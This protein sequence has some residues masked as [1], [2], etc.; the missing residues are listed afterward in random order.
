M[1]LET[2]GVNAG[3]PSATPVEQGVNSTAPST[4]VIDQQFTATSPDTSVV[5]TD[6]GVPQGA[7]QQ[8]SDNEKYRAI[9]AERDRVQFEK[10]QLQEQLNQTQRQTTELMQRF[11]PQQQQTNPYDPQ[12][13]NEQYWDWKL[14]QKNKQLLVES[15]R[16]YESKLMGLLQ[17]A[18]EQS[19]VQQHPDV[20]VSQIK[21]QIKYRWG[22]ENPS[23]SM[24]EDFHR[25]S[26]EPSRVQQTVQSAVNQVATTNN[27][28]NI[29]LVRPSAQP[30]QNSNTFD[31]D[32][33]ARE[34]TANPS[35]LNKMSPE[36][37]KAFEAETMRTLAAI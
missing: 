29:N 1:E 20:N 31:F 16:M 4:V 24:I 12:T 22:V 34:V 19:W 11:A 2:Q 37:R 6:T 10:S 21:S 5:A 30:I 9:Q 33:L 18:S 28:Q 26:T 13:Q 27:Q 32:K 35:L 17:Q 7:P 15:E 25:M 23:V 3:Q 36:L 14:D 8:Q